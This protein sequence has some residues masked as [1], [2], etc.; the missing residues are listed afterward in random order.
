MQKT[1]NDLLDVAIGI[2]NVG[3]VLESVGLDASDPV[4]EVVAHRSDQSV[5]VGHRGNG[6]KR[7]VRD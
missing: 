4:L 1:L 3:Q 5:P 6:T 2:G 7:Q